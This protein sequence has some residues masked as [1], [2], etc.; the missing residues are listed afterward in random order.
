MNDFVNMKETYSTYEELL[1]KVKKQELEINQLKEIDKSITNFEFF[2]NES[3]DLICIASKD[4]VFKEINSSF[5]KV[6]GYSKSEMNKKNPFTDFIHPDDKAKTYLEI[7]KISPRNPSVDFENRYIKKNGEIV[8]FQWRASLNSVNNLIYAIARDITEIRNSQEKLIASEKL[9]NE[10]QKIAKTGSWEYNLNTKVLLCTDEF[11][12][13]HEIENKFNPELYLDYLSQLSNEDISLLKEKIQEAIQGK[14][15][16]EIEYRIFLSNNRVKWVYATGIPILDANGTVF[17]LRGIGQDITEKKLIAEAL[18]E[19]EQKNNEALI[20]STNDLMWSVDRDFKLIIGNKTFINHMSEKYGMSLVRGANLL[21]LEYFPEDFIKFWKNLYVKVLNGESVKI[22]ILG[23]ESKKSERD[24]FETNINPIYNDNAI[25]GLACF[26]RNITERKKIENDLLESEENYRILV[27]QASDGILIADE[28]GKLINVNASVSKLTNYSEKELLQ[29]SI[30]D[31]ALPEDIEINPFHFDDLQKGKAVVTER[32]MR[33]KNN[34][35]FHVELTSKL[36]FD[37]RLLVFARDISRRKKIE[38]KLKE[39]EQFLKETQIIAN[40]GTYSIDVI[41]GKWTSSEVLNTIFGIDASF[42]LSSENWMSTII[43]PDWQKPMTDYLTDE[44]VGKRIPFNKEY[45]IIRVNDQSERWVHGKGNMK[46]NDDNQPISVVGTIRDITSRKLMEIELIKA[47]EQAEAANKS[48]SDFLA[49]MSH[50]IRTPLNGIIG[51][52]DLLLKTNLEKNQSEYMNTVKESANTLMEIINDIL[53]FS[54]IESGKLE[55]NIEEVNLF[56]LLNQVVDLF[57][58]QA[59]IKN[60]DLILN[61]ENGVPEFIFM[62]SLRLK[63]ILVNLI[64]NALKFTLAGTIEIT[65]KELRAIN[66]KLST[67]HFSVKDSGIGIKQHNQEKIFFSFV[68]E[69]NTTTRKFGGTGLG[70]AISNQLLGLMQSKLQ[71]IS[72]FGKGSDFHFT[73]DIKKAKGKVSK[74]KLSNENYRKPVN[75]NNIKILVVEDNKIN[76]LLSKTLLKRILPNC[77]IFE[78]SSGDAAIHLFENEPLD[79]ILMD[80]Q[81]PE[82]NGYETTA[83][84][85][86][87]K[88]SQHIPIIAL[89]AGIMLDEK[90]KCIKAGMNDYISKPIIECELEEKIFQWIR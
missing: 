72:E 43:H 4:G 39:S 64:S 19:N 34:I 28:T 24:W 65:I 42:E 86:A 52:S 85:R 66:E 82:K 88:K 90:E 30:H 32:V 36:L 26:A 38:T 83:E 56:E 76:M 75:I 5:Q 47:K 29:L 45:K 77:I 10:A 67:L 20:N 73:L 17:G 59:I 57:K 60:I 8:F 81:M 53:D 71:L 12:K 55:L 3:L 79:L 87:L 51:F 46:W 62:D 44:V 14:K 7:G 49:N 15:S 23:P 22:E 27:E 54:K 50:E 80:I 25:I 69:D 11:H 78:A 35:L 33:G 2:I 89:T 74:I 68:Q 1:K 61:V 41:T 84:I 18:I 37:G 48:K 9:L 58:H 63:Q 40:L 16:Y 70:L 13:I 21:N 31:F 6:L